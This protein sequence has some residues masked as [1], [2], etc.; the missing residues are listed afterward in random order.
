MTIKVTSKAVK[1]EEAAN[2]DNATANEEATDT[3]A[4]EATSQAAEPA[5]APESATTVTTAQGKDV[6]VEPT[7]AVQADV[8]SPAFEGY[9]NAGGFLGFFGGVTVKVTAGEG[10]LPEGTRVQASLVENSNLKEAMEQVAQSN[11]TELVDYTAID[12]VLTDANGNEIQP[13][14]AVNVCFFGSDV[15]GD[16]MVIYRVSDDYATA[17]PISARQLD[18]DVQSFDVNHFSLYV[19]SGGKTIATASDSTDWRGRTTNYGAYLSDGT[20]VGDATI[21]V[22]S[23]WQSLS[24]LKESTTVPDGYEVAEIQYNN[25]TAG[26]LKYA[27]SKNTKLRYSSTDSGD[28]ANADAAKLKVIV[29]QISS[30]DAKSVTISGASSVAQFATVTLTATLDPTTAR[31]TEWTWESGNESILTVSGNGATATITGGAAGTTTV[32]VYATVNGKTVSNTYSVEVTKATESTDSAQFYYLKTPTSNPKSNSTSDWGST[33]GNG[34]VNMTGATWES[35]KNNYDAANRVVSWPSG[36][37]D[38]I[39]PT[40][41]SHWTTIF[42]AFKSTLDDPNITADDVDYIQLIPYKVSKNNGSNPDKHVD[43]TVQIVVKGVSTATYYLWDTADTGFIWKAAENVYDGNTTTYEN[44]DAL[45][46]LPATKTVGGVTYTLV[47]WYDNS[48]LSGSLVAFPYTVTENVTF[49]AKYVAGR[50]ITYDLDGG[51]WDAASSYTKNAGDTAYV[52]TVTPTKDGYTFDGWEVTEGGVEVTTPGASFTMPD[53]NVAFK[54]KWVANSYNYTVNYYLYG[55]TTSI[56]SATTDTATIGST[57]ALTADQ[58]AIEGYTLVAV[59][60]ELTVSSD[61][62]KNVIN[63]YYYKAVTVTAKDASKEYGAADP[64]LEATVSGL[65][66]SDHIDYTVSRAEG[67]E[68]GT[69][70]ITAEGEAI[71][72]Y[73]K[74]TYVPGIFTITKSSAEQ[75]VTIKGNTGSKTYTGTDQSVAG[76]TVEGL[77]DKITVTYTGAGTPAATGTNADTYAM[78]LSKDDFAATSDYYSNI[79]IVVEDGSLTVAPASLTVTTD[80]GNKVYDGKPLTV[81]TYTVEGLVNGENLVIKTTG[82]QTAVGSSDNTFEA[83]WNAEG[84]TA[85]EG[86]YTITSSKLGTLVVTESAQEISVVTTGGT[87]TYDGQ[88]H[89]A[90]VEVQNL[91]EGYTLEKAASSA[92]ATHVA[93]GTVTAK[94]DTLVIKNAAG[95]DVTS[96]LNIKYTDGSITIKPA[97]LTVTTPD[98]EKVY[99]GTALTAEG[100]ITGFVNNETATFETT[101]TQTAVGSSD[102]T[103]SIT[104]NGTAQSGDYKVVE[105]KIGKLTVTESTAEI[106]VTTTGGTFT[107]DG[108]AHGATVTV[109]TLPAG[110]TLET[111]TSNASATHVTTD[112]VSA[113]CD[114]LIIRNA[115]GE[116]VTSKLNVKYVDGSIAITPAALKVTT[117]SEEKVYDG[118]ALTAEGS[119]TG[120][121]NGE[122]ATF[123]TTGSQTTVGTSDN[124]YSIT[125]NGTAQSG[126][127][128][129]SATV[130][131]LTVTEYAGEVT[132]TTTGGTFTYDGQAHGATVTVTGLPTGYTVETATSDDTATHVADGTVTATCDT[133]VIENAAGEDVTSKLNVKYVNGSIAITPATLM[134]TTPD[135]SKVY[136]GMALTKAG[137][138][139]GLIGEETVTFETTGSQ[140]AV[141]SSENTYTLT[142]DKTAAE[143]D[144]KVVEGKIGKLTVTE[145]TAEITVTTTGGTFTYDGQA[146]GAT[147]TVT[148][149]PTGYTV[150]TAASSATATHVTLGEGDE[151]TSVPAT[152]DTL[153][154][155]NAQGEDVTSKLNVKKVDGSIAIT[156]AALTVTTPSANKAYDGTALT[157]EGTITGLVNGETVTFATTGS[158]TT[159]G[160]SD[161]TYTLAFDGT[162]AESDYK[163]SANVGKLTVTESENTIVITAVGGIYTYD[164]T[165]HAATIEVSNLPAGYKYE[166]TVSEGVTD[167]TTGATATVTSYKIYNTEG[168]DVTSQLKV[169]TVAG[170]IVVNPRPITF[171]GNS[172]TAK[173]DGNE[174]SVEGYTVTSDLGLVDGQAATLEAK[175]SGTEVGEY[176]GTITAVSDVAIKDANGNNVTA[177]YSITTVPGK[178]TITATAPQNV[179]V[180]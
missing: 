139:S 73:Y 53:N 31:A 180:T 143:S 102:N 99:D 114:T 111:A 54:A 154:I 21:S 131:K 95:E 112:A 62:S 146:H 51:T 61:E 125:W 52:T 179:Y 82:T 115:A 16:Q 81:G 127:Y 172:G 70:A 42:N 106:T 168:K 83:Q 175:A 140:T 50:T 80:G 94:C 176:V 58:L 167:V 89:G 38:G 25:S 76:Y 121:V 75:V 44:F 91:P 177:N 32:A 14:G 77:G 84:T 23:T 37:E 108:Q 97:A 71:Q 118:T 12:V 120:F 96:K 60:D 132:V 173:F 22:T 88:A 92:T 24:A 178:M 113:T 8:S 165:A 30:E 101:G 93:D 13:N 100:T 29:Q 142:F 104:W 66:N 119:I 79:T 151:P 57:V 34:T 159:V 153:V 137:S 123:K 9:A 3:A 27:S 126:D 18:S 45:K 19:V 156:P 65:R 85:S 174:H 39:V 49:Y 1:A 72:G 59:P 87:F 129:V 157:A 63:V 149:L 105:D 17:T 144:Y 90:T 116:D 110:Y 7:V 145:S 147:V 103:Y 164:G 6:T 152:C 10:V 5:Q 48:N 161:N 41:S 78:G 109:S 98:A 122:T 68:P 86:N 169:E 15:S 124:T 67:E 163:V 166:A 158:Q 55:T 74:V 148:G 107:Y 11:G 134:V 117:P 26:Y 138:I 33:I 170:T 130:G 4:S 150:E 135:A 160:T 2:T 36:F 35:S 141:G 69:Y 28:G 162:A 56:Q 64:T 136:D 155:K 20:Y 133:L 171:T 128:T 46:S 43:C 47:G 40:T